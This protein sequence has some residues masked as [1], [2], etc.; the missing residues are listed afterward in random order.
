[1]HTMSSMPSLSAVLVW[2]SACVILGILLQAESAFDRSKLPWSS[3][4][5]A[6]VAI[7]K[8]LVSPTLRADLFCDR[9]YVASSVVSAADMLNISK[10]GQEPDINGPCEEDVSE[11]GERFRGLTKK[12]RI[13]TMAKNG[14]AS[15][16]YFEP[17]LVSLLCIASKFHKV[18]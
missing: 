9:P 10:P 14:V 18:L 8:R 3:L 6:C 16:L 15:G 4:V 12:Q 7:V 1:M 11:L 17:M 5:Y 13:S 2:A